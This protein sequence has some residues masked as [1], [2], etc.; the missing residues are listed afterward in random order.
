[1]NRLIK[2]GFF[3]KLKK[4]SHGLKLNQGIL[5][6]TT[7]NVNFSIKLESYTPPF[8]FWWGGVCFVY[9]S[10][11]P[12]TSF[13]IFYPQHFIFLKSKKLFL[14]EYYFIPKSFPLSSISLFRLCGLTMTKS[15]GYNIKGK[16]ILVI[17]ECV[18]LYTL[19]YLLCNS[20]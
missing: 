18:Y 9:F 13:C 6:S 17:T 14:T 15:Q 4:N 5:N 3:L 20:F 12:P 2:L 7:C 16:N 1:M 10:P 11:P 8:F 19:H